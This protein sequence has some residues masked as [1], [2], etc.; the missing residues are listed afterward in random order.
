MFEPKVSSVPTDHGS[1][2]TESGGPGYKHGHE[3][4]GNSGIN[5]GQEKG[6][7]PRTVCSIVDM[8]MIFTSSSTF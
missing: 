8:Y 4:K 1:H 5:D 6:K 3:D 7:Q 2:N